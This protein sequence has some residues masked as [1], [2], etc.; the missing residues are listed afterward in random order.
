MKIKYAE[1]PSKCAE[2]LSKKP[3]NTVVHS[4]PNIVLLVLRSPCQNQQNV[5]Q[6]RSKAIQ[7]A[8]KAVQKPTAKS[9]KSAPMT[10]ESDKR[11]NGK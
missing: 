5:K 3:M 2:K 1:K 7:M 6:M 4:N 8:P 11:L 10:N 9:V